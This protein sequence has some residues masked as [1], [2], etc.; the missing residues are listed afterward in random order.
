MS[1]A[2]IAEVGIGRGDWGLLCDDE[3]QHTCFRRVDQ[4]HKI[5]MVLSLDPFV[6]EL[7]QSDFETPSAQAGRLSRHQ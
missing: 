6:L 7:M 3:A 5:A 2:I 1:R 4:L